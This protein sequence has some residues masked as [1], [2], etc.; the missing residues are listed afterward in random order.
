[1][2]RVA[3]WLDRMAAQMNPILFFVMIVLGSLDA[4]AFI[5]LHVPTVAPT[6]DQ[7]QAT[8]SRTHGPARTPLNPSPAF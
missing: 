5:A 6:A 3:A 4:L 2:K 8:Y 7:L 1:M